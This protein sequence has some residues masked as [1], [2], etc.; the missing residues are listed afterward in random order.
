[1]DA[2]LLVAHGNHYR[3]I[4]QPEQALSCYA[5]AFVQDFNN[6]HAWNKYGNVIR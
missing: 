1:M 2:E 6:A 4:N 5:Q 3:E